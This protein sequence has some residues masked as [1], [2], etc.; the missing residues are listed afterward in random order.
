MQRRLSILE[1]QQVRRRPKPSRI[2]FDPGLQPE[3]SGFRDVL[4]V[5]SLVP[6]AAIGAVLMV[7][8]GAVRLARRVVSQ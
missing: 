3:G 6:I 7:L 5:V 1:R 4:A 2:V 8:G